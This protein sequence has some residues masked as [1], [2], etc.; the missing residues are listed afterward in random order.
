MSL[1][2]QNLG[3]NLQFGLGRINA[4]RYGPHK[5]VSVHDGPHIGQWSHKIII[6][7]YNTYHC[8]TVAYSIQY[9]NMP[10]RFVA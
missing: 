4:Y 1:L 5:D 7:Y 10:Y 8:V 9:S 6:L 2:T 3:R